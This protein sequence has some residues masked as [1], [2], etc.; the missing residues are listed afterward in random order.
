VTNIKQHKLIAST[1]GLWISY[2]ALIISMGLVEEDFGQD[3]CCHWHVIRHQ[4]THY[5]TLRYVTTLRSGLCCR[6]SV[7]R[8]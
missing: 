5:V 4:S 3:Y 1:Q 2:E 8:L 6:R 7:C